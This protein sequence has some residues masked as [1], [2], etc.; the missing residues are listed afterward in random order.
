MSR[1]CMNK[2]KRLEYPCQHFNESISTSPGDSSKDTLDYF[3]VKDP[4][5]LLPKTQKRLDDVPG[6]PVI[7]NC[8]YYTENIS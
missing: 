4:K 3:L 8:G 1:E 5:Y 2:F 7:L 6:G